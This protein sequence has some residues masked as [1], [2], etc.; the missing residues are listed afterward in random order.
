MYLS[1]ETEDNWNE[2]AYIRESYGYTTAAIHTFAPETWGDKNVVHISAKVLRSRLPK[3]KED[4]LKRANGDEVY[5]K[6]HYDAF[7]YFVEQAEKLEKLLGP[8]YYVCN[9]Y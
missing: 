7:V 8:N 2:Y 5:A 6:N 9:S 4:C 1:T 3:V